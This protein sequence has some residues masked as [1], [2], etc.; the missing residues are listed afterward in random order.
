MLRKAYKHCSK[1]GS[2]MFIQMFLIKLLRKEPQCCSKPDAMKLCTDDHINL[3]TFVL[4]HLL[5]IDLTN[6]DELILP[7]IINHSPAFWSF[8][9]FVVP[10]NYFDLL[11]HS[12]ECRVKRPQRWWFWV[13]PFVPKSQWHGMTIW[14]SLKPSILQLKP[15]KLGVWK[16]KCPFG[17]A[18]FQ[19]FY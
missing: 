13:A 9:S 10:V 6:E 1:V 4:L 17:M 15:L 16:M 5:E 2:Q 12:P 7:E 19:K 8:H 11:I 3:I 18:H 14:K